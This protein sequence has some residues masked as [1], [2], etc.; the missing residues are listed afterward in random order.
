MNKKIRNYS[1]QHTGNRNR[2]VL[3]SKLLSFCLAI[4]LPCVMFVFPTAIFAWTYDEIDSYNGLSVRSNGI[5]IPQP[6]YYKDWV[7]LEQGEAEYNDD[8]SPNPN[9]VHTDTTDDDFYAVGKTGRV[10][11]DNNDLADYK[12]TLNFSEHNIEDVYKLDIKAFYNGPAS[13]FSL[14]IDFDEEKLEICGAEGES[15]TDAEL[16]ENVSFPYKTPIMADD[17]GESDLWDTEDDRK[18]LNHRILNAYSGWA[19]I[20]RF[21]GGN[22]INRMYTMSNY[23]ASNNISR[24]DDPTHIGDFS[25]MY[26]TKDTKGAESVNQSLNPVDVRDHLWF[27]ELMCPT[28]ASGNKIGLSLGTVYFK[29]RQGVNES[30][31]APT[32]FKV[33]RQGAKYLHASYNNSVTGKYNEIYFSGADI[34]QLFNDA[35]RIPY[36]ANLEVNVFGEQHIEYHSHLGVADKSLLKITNSTRINDDEITQPAI[37]AVSGVT[38]VGTITL[39]KYYKQQDD[40]MPTIDTPDYDPEHPAI[41]GWKPAPNG[42]LPNIDGTGVYFLMADV[43]YGDSYLS[44]RNIILDQTFEILPVK[45]ITQAHL[46]LD[47]DYSYRFYESYK[48][49]LVR[50]RSDLTGTGDVSIVAY[51][52]VGANSWTAASEYTLLGDWPC[53]EYKLL[54]KVTEGTEWH[55]T[56]NFTTGQDEPIELDRIFSVLSR[57]DDSIIIYNSNGGEYFPWTQIAHTQGASLTIVPEIPVRPGY[58]FL[59]WLPENTSGTKLYQPGDSIITS[60]NFMLPTTKLN[61]V[62]ESI[63]VTVKRFL[64]SASHSINENNLTVGAISSETS[65]SSFL[66][67]LSGGVNYLKFYKN[68]SEITSGN[69]GT[70][71]VISIEEN[72]IVLQTLTAVVTGDVDGDGSISAT[73]INALKSD[74]LGIT[75]L[76]VAQ[77]SAACIVSE[78]SPDLTDLVILKKYLAGQSQIVTK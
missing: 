71:T 14:D 78:S 66:S 38:G 58:T 39:T 35:T 1:Q 57:S 61:A 25:I 31:L 36:A 76:T 68:G 20:A 33:D 19:N 6:L 48:A 44:A 49:P 51:K 69:I 24:I 46:E 59:G 73:D 74:L 9:Y 28:D 8:G 23:F 47:N 21:S 5:N 11:G 15:L 40:E 26:N 60:I 27:Y 10:Y 2:W 22:I 52:L 63:P 32:D 53:G 13:S 50:L 30:D 34:V 56:Y 18:D 54:I 62:W 72:G 64:T 43:D 4:L 41:P 75:T 17:W 37:C 45:K 16:L 65:L 77:K 67:G 55:G 7:L 3:F 12:Y 70:G 42:N 29:L